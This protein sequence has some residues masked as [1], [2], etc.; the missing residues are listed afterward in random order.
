LQITPTHQHSQ[1]KSLP[2]TSF[3]KSVTRFFR[4]KLFGARTS[5]KHRSKNIQDLRQVLDGNQLDINAV[6][7][8]DPR[9]L[10]ILVS[11]NIAASWIFYDTQ[12]RKDTEILTFLTELGR[13]AVAHWK[14]VV[15][16]EHGLQ[17]DGIICHAFLLILVEAYL[18]R[19]LKT[20]PGGI[21]WREQALELYA[22]VLR[23]DPGAES[24][25]EDVEK[26]QTLDA[27]HLTYDNT[28]TGGCVS[29]EARKINLDMAQLICA[30]EFGSLRVYEV[31]KEV[32]E[33]SGT[34]R[35]KS[36][37]VL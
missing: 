29:E 1:S 26:W 19:Y 35:L 17:V 5:T 32:R 36:N 33:G 22:R 30:E 14:A 37:G 23:D 15:M 25:D 18:E 8:H 9:G 3:F 12:G 28:T 34:I 16:T 21:Y 31:R 6:G 2:S 11:K 10:A 13:Q 24:H 20:S 4:R 7:K 27:N